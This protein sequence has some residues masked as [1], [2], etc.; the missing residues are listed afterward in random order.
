MIG[1][2]GTRSEEP[3]SIAPTF[4]HKSLHEKDGVGV[5]T[6]FEPASAA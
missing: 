2:D 5:P 6:G 3:V 4:I 1:L